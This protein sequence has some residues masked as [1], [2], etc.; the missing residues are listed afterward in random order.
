M[1]LK[2]GRL[3]RNRATVF[4]NNQRKTENGADMHIVDEKQ[5]TTNS[6]T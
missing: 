1:A 4:L 6:Q 3:L 2:R 5:I